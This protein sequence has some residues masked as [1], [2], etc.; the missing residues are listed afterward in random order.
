MFCMLNLS[1]RQSHNRAQ[2]WTHFDVAMTPTFR[3]YYYA[4]SQE[5]GKK[6]GFLPQNLWRQPML[7]YHYKIWLFDCTRIHVLSIY[8]RTAFR[9]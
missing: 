2:D 9:A 7:K 5:S 4:E 3:I 6:L 8:D 1:E